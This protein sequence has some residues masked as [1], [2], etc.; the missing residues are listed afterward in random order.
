MVPP[1]TDISLYNT[2]FHQR[3]SCR[4]VLLDNKLCTNTKAALATCRDIFPSGAANTGGLQRAA[5]SPERSPS[6]P[7]IGASR[8]SLGHVTLL[9]CCRILK[10]VRGL[11]YLAVLTLDLLVQVPSVYKFIL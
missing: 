7:N 8:K 3:L 9:F 6:C 11:T 2:F 5:R 10:C 4:F 1:Y